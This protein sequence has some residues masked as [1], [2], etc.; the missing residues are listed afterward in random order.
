MWLKL[1]E[2][3]HAVGKLSEAVDAYYK[4]LELAPNQLG[5]TLELANLCRRLG[6]TGEARSILAGLS[7]KRIFYSQLYL[8]YYRH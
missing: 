6:R 7:L 3:R 5:V 1:A 4:V 2:C 8:S